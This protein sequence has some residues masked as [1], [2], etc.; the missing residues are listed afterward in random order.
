MI[1]K[2]LKSKV[3]RALL[4]FIFA[5]VFGLFSAKMT[6][7]RFAPFFL[8]VCAGLYVGA[9]LGTIIKDWE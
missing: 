1:K 3:F 9:L 2:A 4:P 5:A 7:S 6:G 8:S